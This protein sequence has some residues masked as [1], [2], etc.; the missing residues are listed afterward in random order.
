MNKI[1]K[2]INTLDAVNEYVKISE[3]FSKEA[4]RA[5]SVREV[6]QIYKRYMAALDGRFKSA[7][8]EYNNVK[9]IMDKKLLMLVDTIQ[10]SAFRRR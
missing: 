8:N 5:K 10:S 1:A 2:A 9:K 6:N 4:E 3:N 7:E